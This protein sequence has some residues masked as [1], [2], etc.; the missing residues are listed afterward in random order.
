MATQ[1]ISGIK[2]FRERMRIK[3]Q[4]ELAEK[5]GVEQT[6]VSVWEL[7]KSMP[8]SKIMQKLLELGATVEELFE[9]K[10]N[11]IHNLGVQEA[12]PK[13]YGDDLE[14]KIMKKLEALETRIDELEEL[15]KM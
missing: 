5:L 9:V 11:E 15:K 14:G 6:S 4:A 10:Y 1:K 2:C 7:G 3:T 13:K 12:V 8:G